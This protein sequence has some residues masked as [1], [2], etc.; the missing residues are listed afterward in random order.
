MPAVRLVLTGLAASATMLVAAACGGV[1]TA[2]A[3]SIT[4][5]DLVSELAT[6]LS[7]SA[8]LSYTATYQLAGGDEAQITQTQKPARAA[9]TYPGGLMIRT[10]DATTRCRGASSA[11]KCTQTRP[12]PA[13][14]HST[15]MLTTPESVLAMLN[16]AAIDPSA[17]AKQHDTTIAGHHATCLALTG[18]A[19]T[20][21][22]DFSV[23]VTAEGALGSFTATMGGKQADLALT[24]YSDKPDASAFDLPPS[25]KVTDQRK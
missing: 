7:E 1:D 3:A 15:G 17:T 14:L 5:D 9:Y 2:N 22:P 10:S 18:V 13:D 12:D 20:P 4:H 11:L 19:H 25:A 6:Q 23:C 8:T 24:A 21:T 16:Q